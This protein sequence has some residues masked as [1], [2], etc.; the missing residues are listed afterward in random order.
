MA[1]G[2]FG[3]LVL[4]LHR[5]SDPEHLDSLCRRLADLAVGVV[6][7]GAHPVASGLRVIAREVRDMPRFEQD[8]R[9][10]RGERQGLADRRLRRRRIVLADR[11]G[12]REIPVKGV[13]R[14]ASGRLPSLWL[15]R[16]RGRPEP[17]RR[18]RGQGA[19][20]ALLRLES[21]KRKRLVEIEGGF[22]RLIGCDP[23]I[24]SR[25]VQ[26]RGRDPCRATPW[27]LRR[28]PV[29]RFRDRRPSPQRAL[30][31]PTHRW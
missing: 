25:C 18:G 4:R 28:S 15:G 17:R 3:G 29:P 2:H 24:A 5:R 21:R 20:P 26:L 7:G 31:R 22:S 23:Q 30:G 14:N 16:S 9:I 11:Q 8:R 12:S 19:L 6:A 1:Q 13:V 27:R 10:G